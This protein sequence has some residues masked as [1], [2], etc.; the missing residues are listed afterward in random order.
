MPYK[1]RANKVAAK[2]RYRA[3]KAFKKTLDYALKD[4]TDRVRQEAAEALNGMAE[5]MENKIKSSMSQVGI[6]DDTGALRGSVKF[7]RA[8]PDK[9]KVTI[10]S[11]VYKPAPKNPGSRNP[12][13][14]GRYKK[15]VP[16]GRILEFS[17]HYKKY[18]GFFY[19]Q[20]Y[21]NRDAVR[22]YIKESIS[23]AWSGK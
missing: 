9:L 21:N 14:I 7:T 10:K 15:G 18:N 1:D 17:T 6:H 23:K 11:E 19:T 2:R 4:A 8:K 3:R 12:N 16:Y 13:M 5:F 20:W 22:E